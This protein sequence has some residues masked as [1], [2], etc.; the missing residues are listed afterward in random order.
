MDLRTALTELSD[1]DPSSMRCSA[2]GC[3]TEAVWGLRW[4]NPKLHT[5]ER[6]KVWL[7][8]DEHERSLRDFLG[9]RG[10]FIDAVPVSDLSPTDG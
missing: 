1:A 5:S 4:N 6:R 9:M 8:C 2:K 10:F 3:R 7:A